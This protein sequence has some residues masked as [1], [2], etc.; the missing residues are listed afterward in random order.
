[1]HV[2]IVALVVSFALLFGC[3]DCEEDPPGDPSA[4]ATDVV[5]TT[6]DATEDTGAQDVSDAADTAD[7]QDTS[8]TQ[9]ADTADASASTATVTV[10]WG[11]EGAPGVRVLAHNP[12]ATV[13]ADL[14]TDANGQAVVEVTEGSMITLIDALPNDFKRY[15]TL[16][17]IDPG[18]SIE[19]AL[20]PNTSPRH[21]LEVDLPGAFSGAARYELQGACNYR[22]TI[23][24]SDTLNIGIRAPCSEDDVDL[25]ALAKDSDD[26]VLAYAFAEDVQTSGDTTSVS[27]DSWN[28]DLL[29][30]DIELTGL[31]SSTNYTHS[32]NAV[33]LQN[34][35]QWYVS[36]RS[37]GTSGATSIQENVQVPPTFADELALTY[38]LNYTSASSNDRLSNVGARFFSN[39]DQAAS[40]TIPAAELMPE[41]STLTVEDRNTARPAVDWD[42]SPIVSNGA[43]ADAADAAILRVVWTANTP[44][45]ANADGS[46][47]EFP[48][49]SPNAINIWVMVAPTSETSLR[50]PE[51]PDDLDTPAQGSDNGVSAG[52]LDAREVEDYSGFKAAPDVTNLFQ[53]EAAP[54]YPGLSLRESRAE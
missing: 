22:G 14:N 3:G 24:G 44:T 4:D 43:T 47:G 18:D 51:V 38:E 54:L 53:F 16:Q 26:Q 6:A 1:M 39:R 29:S 28:T 49:V 12:D 23:D 41:L 25:L 33:L 35:R 40:A 17:D 32:L 27:L 30:S 7:A 8:D 10:T 9:D 36:R 20:P 37:G 5:D 15:L 11:G 50:L 13:T 31:P 21:S 2:R 52:L 19:L 34:Y 46:R 45:S 42:A 48:G